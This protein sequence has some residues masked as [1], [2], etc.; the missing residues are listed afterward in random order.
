MPR[1]EQA[2]AELESWRIYV[3]T[4]GTFTDALGVGPDGRRWRGKLL[5]SEDAPRR[6]VREL[7]GVAEG[8]GALPP[9][10][11]RLA[12]T[13]GT[14]ALL[15]EN[16][17]EVVFFVTEG[18]G[19]L[20]RIGDQRR[21]DLFA[22]N[23]FK[24]APLHAEVVEV[25]GRLDSQGN[26]I[27]SLRTELLKQ[28]ADELVARGRRVAAVMLLHS[29]RNPA[30]EL[31][32]KDVLLECGFEYVACSCQLA[33]FI[34]AVPRA[35]T[36]VVDA[37]LG[38][39]MTEYLDGVNEALSGGSLQVMNSAGGLVSRDYY[40]PKDSLLSG[41][42]AGV[43]GAA[44]VGKIAGLER[45]IAFD[46]GGTSTDVSRFDG[47]S[48]YCQ[49]HQVGRAHLMAPALQIETVAAGGGSICGIE[50]GFLFVGPQ[51]AGAEPGP[52]CYGVGGPL[53]IT[54]INL[55]LGR[56][57]LD[58][59]NLPVFPDAAETRFEEVHSKHCGTR[60]E[61]LLG[62]L[63]LANERMASNIRKISV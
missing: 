21:P 11:M 26:L 31:A 62:F 60:E 37:Y 51:S 54:D 45:L 49:T 8:R 24:P 12:T 22:L 52:A 36:T 18:F 43:V 1:D 2:T 39:L 7:T 48:N 30:H 29:Y 17:A 3:D 35:E 14:N 56:L 6:A 13:R 47:D 41:P 32:V 4:G 40:R 27:Q 63:A 10:Q 55:L 16:G 38:P 57:D 5:S 59:F 33:P 9:V 58:S 15:E 25:P 53:T 28:K 46:M 19:G 44:T 50:E 34:K 61:L 20:L 42:A 23:V